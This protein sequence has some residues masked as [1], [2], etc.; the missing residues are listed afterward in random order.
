MHIQKDG[1]TEDQDLDHDPRYKSITARLI[2]THQ[3]GLPNWRYQNRGMY[4][5]LAFDPGTDFEELTDAIGEKAQGA[6]F[7]GETAP[8]LSQELS[9]LAPH[10]HQE[11]V[12][13]LPQ[14]LEEAQK[15]AQPGDTVLLTPACASFD[16]FTN[17]EERGNCF[18][19]WVRR[20]S[21]NEVS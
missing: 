4:L 18:R 21:D 10:I 8:Q 17:Y 11:V 20:R 6:V 12:D 16:Q 14:A 15:R 7:Y 2:L 5:N 3:T 19:Q 1:R 13:T 9:R